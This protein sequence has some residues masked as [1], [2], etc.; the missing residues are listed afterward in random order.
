GED[1]LA[2]LQ[3][4]R[5]MGVHIEGPEAGQLRIHGVGVEGLKPASAPLYLGNSGT[6]MRLLAGL[7]AGQTFGSVLTGD[8]SLSTRPMKRVADPLRLMGADITLRDGGLAPI[9]IRP[10]ALHGIDFTMPVAS[11]QVKSCL[12]LAG[13]YAEGETR[14]VEPAPCRDHTER[15]LRAFGYPVDVQGP[16]V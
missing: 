8:S 11:A 15:M 2:T 6:S 5:D 14:V 13:L 3:S 9:E 4:F 10:A 7:L 1:A 12:L 16:A